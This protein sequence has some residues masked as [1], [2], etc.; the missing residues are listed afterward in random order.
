MRSVA[1]VALS[2]I[3]IIGFVSDQEA[4]SEGGITV[5][6]DKSEYK[7][8]DTIKI[9]GQFETFLEGFPPVTITVIDPTGEVVTVASDQ[10]SLASAGGAEYSVWLTAGED[11]NIDGEYTVN[12]VYGTQSASTTFLYVA[13][14]ST[15]Q[16]TCDLNSFNHP[17][18]VLDIFRSNQLDRLGQILAGETIVLT[19]RLV[20][21]SG[22]KHS[23]VEI[24]IFENRLIDSDETLVTTYTDT[25]GE[26]S[27]LW[28]VTTDDTITGLTTTIQAKYPTKSWEEG[29]RYAPVSDK[30]LIQI[31]RQLAE[32]SLDPL[33]KSAEIG[34]TLFF[35]GK[36]GL[37]S[38]DPEGFI[39]YIKD[40]DPFEDD[41]LLAT[42]YVESNGSFSANWIVTNTDSDRIT[43]VYA[44]FEYESEIFYR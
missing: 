26:F 19:G 40:E 4:Y 32:I 9:S 15:D 11:V 38:G 10:P 13:T 24:I 42:G 7:E 31:K 18:V 22:Y 30:H 33:P 27:V 20:C 16:S 6:T 44:V 17:T 14:G 23:N 34:E 21:E 29:G 36:L 8:G 3:F 25:N 5:T 2:L 39:I 1:L 43:D 12:A 37:A 41:D 28:L 35:T